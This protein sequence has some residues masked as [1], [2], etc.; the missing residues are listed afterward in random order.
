[1]PF[2]DYYCQPCDKIW[3]EQHRM[4]DPPIEIC[5]FCQQ[6]TAVRQISTGTSFTLVGSGWAADNYSKKS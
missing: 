5:P 6:K 2:Y 1:M 4:V 3:E